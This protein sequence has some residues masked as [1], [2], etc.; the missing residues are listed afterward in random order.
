[1]TQRI[2]GKINSSSSH[3]RFF[4]FKPGIILQLWRIAC[5]AVCPRQTLV[6]ESAANS[7]R[8]A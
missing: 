5:D 4:T 2:P 6:S 7:A 1:M 8:G 3:R